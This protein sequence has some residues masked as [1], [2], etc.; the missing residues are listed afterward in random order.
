MQHAVL[1]TCSDIPRCLS[2]LV[3]LYMYQQSGACPQVDV[4]ACMVR[5]NAIGLEVFVPVPCEERFEVLGGLRQS[6]T[7]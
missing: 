1:H 7:G 6:S 2:G 3:A 4:V 5:G